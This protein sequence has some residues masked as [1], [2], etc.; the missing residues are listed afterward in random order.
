MKY[1]LESFCDILNLKNLVH[2][3][4]CFMKNSKSITDLILTNKLLNFQKK[5]CC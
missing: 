4:V 2:W 5:R 3:E 1:N